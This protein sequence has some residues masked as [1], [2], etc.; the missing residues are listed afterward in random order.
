MGHTSK[1]KNKDEYA[2]FCGYSINHSGN[3]YQMLHLQ[4]KTIILSRDIKW[5]NRF[6]DKENSTI[7]EEDENYI[8]IKSIQNPIP[9][10]EPAT[11]IQINNIDDE[12]D[13]S[14]MVPIPTRISRELS[15]LRTLTAIFPEMPILG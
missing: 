9:V 7:K 10:N 15:N 11:N 12:D 5:L 13:Q 3:V 14:T 1:I 2:V 8:E 4:T 6:M